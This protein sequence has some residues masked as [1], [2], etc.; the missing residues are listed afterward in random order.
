[1]YN[2]GKIIIGIIIFLVL[3]TF[4]FW[5]NRGVAQAPPKLEVGT[6]EKQCVESTPFMKANHMKLLVDWRDYVVR[7]GKREYTST[8]GKKFDMSLQNTC[9]KCHTQKTKFCD[10]CHDYVE[11]APTCWDCHIAPVEPGQAQQAKALRSSN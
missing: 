9:M 10:R 5:F 3:A 4:P 8:T 1:M 7:D 11:V 6:Q 2:S